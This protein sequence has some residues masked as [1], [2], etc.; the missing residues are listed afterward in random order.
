[1]L[2]VRNL[3]LLQLRF[4]LPAEIICMHPKPEVFHIWKGIKWLS[5]NDSLVYLINLS[6]LFVSFFFPFFLLSG[7]IVWISCYLSMASISKKHINMVTY[8]I[9]ESDNKK[10]VAMPNIRSSKWKINHQL[11][12]KSLVE[13]CKLVE[14]WNIAVNVWTSCQTA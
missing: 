12:S 2:G 14:L 13:K 8:T 9:N 11:R 1:M 6:F 3:D 4:F 10:N 7:V 5:R